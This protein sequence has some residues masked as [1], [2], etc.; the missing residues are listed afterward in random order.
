[1]ASADRAEPAAKK[2][3]TWRASDTKLNANRVEGFATTAGGKSDGW[4]KQPTGA[5]R[6]ATAIDSSPSS[7]KKPTWQRS[8][9]ASTQGGIAESW[10]PER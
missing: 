4:A 2:K 1:V 6:V 9:S 7:S 5:V 3:P 8:S 10:S